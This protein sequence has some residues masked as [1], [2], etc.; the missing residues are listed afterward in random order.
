MFRPL[1]LH[2]SLAL[3]ALAGL[4]ATAPLAAQTPPAPAG[5]SVSITPELPSGPVSV[6]EQPH[7]VVSADGGYVLDLRSKLIWPRCAEGMRWN[8]STCIGQRMLFSYADALQIAASRSQSEGVR[9]RLPRVTELRHLVD[10]NGTP[11]GLHPLLFPKSPSESYW[12]ST[13]T[14]RHTEINQY[15]YANIAQGRTG[16]GGS[17][18][19]P[20][21]GWALDPQTGDG[22]GDVSK[23]TPLAIRFVRSFD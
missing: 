22:V 19:A 2:L 12:T 16:D 1:P 15:D 17:T 14:I 18:L 9:W 5:V 7:L 4:G 23:A 10:K 8:G 3:C 21:L 20:L 13:P 11:P 6:P